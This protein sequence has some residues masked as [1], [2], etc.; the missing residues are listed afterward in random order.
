MAIK[1]LKR[2]CVKKGEN[3]H[4]STYIFPYPDNVGRHKIVK[5]ASARVVL[6]WVTF[7][8]VWFGGAKSG[9]NCVVGVGRFKWYQSHCPAWDGGSVHKPMSVASGHSL[10]RQELGDTMR[11][12]SEDAGSQEGLIVTSHIVWVW[13]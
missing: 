8:E 10:G 4:I 13:E 7:W 6:G 9:Q 11:V 2:V 1:D 5:R 3:I 12:A